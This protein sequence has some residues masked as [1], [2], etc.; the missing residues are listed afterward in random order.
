MRALHNLAVRL[1]RQLSV[2]RYLNRGSQQSRMPRTRELLVKTPAFRASAEND[3]HRL[4][5]FSP[6][7]F[8]LMLLFAPR[9]PRLEE[10]LRGPVVHHH[11]LLLLVEFLGVVL[12]HIGNSNALLGPLRKSTSQLTTGM[13]AQLEVLL[14][15][16]P[17]PD[18]IQLYGV[19]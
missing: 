6:G 8:W 3:A 4:L 5:S 1:K 15:G 12:E 14:D 17:L 10:K 18:D 7:P 19:S 9:R 11:A 2:C 16:Q 13:R